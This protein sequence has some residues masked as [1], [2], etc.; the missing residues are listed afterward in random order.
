MFIHNLILM[1][2]YSVTHD[3][4]SNIDCFHPN[5]KGHSWIAKVSNIKYKFAPWNPSRD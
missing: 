2:H 1:H 3:I 5:F 4:D